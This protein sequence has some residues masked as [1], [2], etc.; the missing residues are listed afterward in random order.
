M[1]DYYQGSTI[2]LYTSYTD[3]YGQPLNAGVSGTTLDIYYYTGGVKTYNVTSGTMTQDLSNPSTFY[4]EYTISQTALLTNNIVQYN[5]MYSGL[6]IQS[7]DSFSVLASAGP[8]PTGIGSVQSSGQ[9]V[10]IGGT[11]I[12]NAYISAALLTGNTYPVTSTVAVSGIYELFLNPGNYYL[13]FNAI[14]YN[15]NSVAITVPTG[16]TTFDL[17]TNTL[18][19]PMNGPITIS[20]TYIMGN[21]FGYGGRWPNNWPDDDSMPPI[22]L[23]GLRISLFNNSVTSDK[24][25]AITYTNASGTFY[26]S[27]YPGKYVLLAEGTQPNNQVYR[28]AYD[29]DVDTAFTNNFRYLGTSQYK[30]LI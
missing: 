22:P 28:T 20:D 29:I 24:A 19:M 4:Y 11:G 25:L 9:V 30:F 14:G 8:A 16:M 23:S 1:A 6:N 12:N 26:M 2:T 18:T 7:T 13:T 5:A 15:P 3:G 27:V 17:G 21:Q 10:D